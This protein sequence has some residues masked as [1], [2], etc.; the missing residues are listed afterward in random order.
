MPDSKMPIRVD[1]PGYWRF[2]AHNTR[3]MAKEMKAGEAKD[4]I[5]KIAEEYEIA[6]QLTEAL[7]RQAPLR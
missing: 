4:I 5:L 2:R 1:D 6:A 3:Q 7:L